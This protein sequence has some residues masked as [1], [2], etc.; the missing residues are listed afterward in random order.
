MNSNLENC[1][2]VGWV[3][4]DFGRFYLSILSQQ[5]FCLNFVDW[6]TTSRS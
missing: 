5:S 6:S 1:F 2:W 3:C 4:G